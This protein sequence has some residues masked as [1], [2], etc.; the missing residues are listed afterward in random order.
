MTPEEPKKLEDFESELTPE[1]RDRIGGD[2]IKL[3]KSHP[4]QISMTEDIKSTTHQTIING[5]R[6]GLAHIETIDQLQSFVNGDLNPTISLIYALIFS[7]RVNDFD[8]ANRLYLEWD[9]RTSHN[10]LKNII[11][12]MMTAISYVYPTK[13]DIKEAYE[14]YLIP[15]DNGHEQG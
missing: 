4:E 7:G 2:L 14:N 11:A 9:K 12:N 1:L 3:F 5:I 10:A 8:D 15:E 6:E 13:L